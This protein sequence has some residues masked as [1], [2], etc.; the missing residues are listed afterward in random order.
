M[1]YTALR[2]D[3][4]VDTGSCSSYSMSVSKIR[5]GSSGVEW[6]MGLTCCGCWVGLRLFGRFE[7]GALGRSVRGRGTPASP[8]IV[9][10]GGKLVMRIG[11]ARATVIPA[12][13][14]A[15]ANW[16]PSLGLPISVVPNTISAA[17]GSTS[18]RFIP[19]ASLPTVRGF[20][21]H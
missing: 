5:E 9:S 20:V 3:L 19:L 18:L 17:M 7:R 16:F 14:A 1:L 15:A 2:L 12:G 8:A 6:T 13:S 11:R 4:G 10:T 21:S